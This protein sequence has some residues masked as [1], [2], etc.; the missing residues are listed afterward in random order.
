MRRCFPTYT[1][2]NRGEVCVRGPAAL[3]INGTS[4]IPLSSQGPQPRYSSSTH[5]RQQDVR[6]YF[7]DSNKYKEMRTSLLNINFEVWRISPRSFSKKMLIFFWQFQ[8]L[9]GLLT[10]HRQW[11]T[12]MRGCF[13]SWPI[14]I[15]Q[16]YLTCW[17]SNTAALHGISVTYR[18]TSSSKLLGRRR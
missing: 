6:N 4:P 7:K 17:D 5:T 9:L 3:N 10:G 12:R 14:T 11:E 2:A 8:P 15:S 13:S 18:G 1:L 16:T